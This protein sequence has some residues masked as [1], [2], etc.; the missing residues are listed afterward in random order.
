MRYAVKNRRET[1]EAYCLGGGSEM[2]R[3]LDPGAPERFFNAFLWGAELSA[4]RDATVVFYEILRDGF[5]TV[6][7][8]TFNFVVKEAF[9]SEYTVID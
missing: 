9:E 2:E 5:G 6:T 3:R 7:D 4:P 1:V 8:V